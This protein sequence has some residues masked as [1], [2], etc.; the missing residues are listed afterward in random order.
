MVAAA[1]LGASLGMAAACILA[2]FV[3]WALE[4]GTWA[5]EIVAL[6]GGLAGAVVAILDAKAVR[7]TEA[8]AARMPGGPPRGVRRSYLAARASAAFGA[9]LVLGAL[10]GVAAAAVGIHAAWAWAG[11]NIDSAGG[12]AGELFALVWF[13]ILFVVLAVASLA[14]GLLVVV[15][16]TLA[17]V[18]IASAHVLM[19]T[20]ERNGMGTWGAALTCIGVGL[21]IL[22]GVEV[23]VTE[24]AFATAPF[25]ALAPVLLAGVAWSWAPTRRLSALGVGAAALAAVAV[26]GAAALGLRSERE[27]FAS[28][29]YPDCAG[30]PVA[31]V[32]CMST[33]GLGGLAAIPDGSRP[34]ADVERDLRAL[35]GS[36]RFDG[37]F[38][39]AHQRYAKATVA[40]PLDLVIHA[41]VHRRREVALEDEE[42]SRRAREAVEREYR[43]RSSAICASSAPP[44]DLGAI[45]AEC[46]A[47]ERCRVDVRREGCDADAGAGAGSDAG[48]ARGSATCI[49]SLKGP[50]V[51]YVRAVAVDVEVVS[52]EPP[53]TS[54]DDA[55]AEGSPDASTDARRDAHADAARAPG[56]SVH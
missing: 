32:A 36:C 41:R 22:V 27:R 30:S 37:G 26:G 44:L 45:Y 18:G 9:A 52:D 20:L 33:D 4:A 35:G 19:S 15:A 13:G 21:G 16:S 6:A 47:T 46:G 5:N 42:L 49:A 11:H 25:A 29:S 14:A 43:A 31:G 48:R 3:R 56:R 34:D 28:Q 39:P 7:M 2:P 38:A 24:A 1:A 50:P 10:A 17:L 51:R 23:V 55:G 53:V 54:D 8:D 12:G 40:A